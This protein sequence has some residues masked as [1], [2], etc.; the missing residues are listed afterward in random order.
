MPCT[1]YC[2]YVVTMSYIQIYME[3]I[4]DLLRPDSE[5]LVSRVGRFVPHCTAGAEGQRNVRRRE[6]SGV[7]C[8]HIRL[9][10]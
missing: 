3:L 7:I 5:N 10:G 9:C 2:S 6:G 1:V 8:R 4:Q